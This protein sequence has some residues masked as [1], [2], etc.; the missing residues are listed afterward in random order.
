[1]LNRYL[2][3]LAA[4]CALSSTDLGAQQRAPSSCD[5]YQVAVRADPKNLDAAARLGRCSF[6][7]Y[8]MVA[9]QGDSSRLAFRS[10]WTT[11]LRALRHAV[12]LDPSYS[13]AYRPLFAI[14]FAETRDGC[15]FATGN[16]THV[17][18]V[19]RDGDSVITTPRLVRLNV[20]GID[21][22]DEVT[23]ESR[24]RNRA[25]LSEARVLAERWATVAA[26]DWR[27]HDYLGR[28]LLRLGD[29]AAAA[30]ELERAAGLGTAANR[31]ELFWDRLEALVK[32][33]RGADARRVLDEAVSDP[34]H[35]TI[36]LGTYAVANLNAILGRIRPPSIDSARERQS[37]ARLDSILRS[38]PPA[39]PIASGFSGLLAA[40][41]TIGARRM[42]ARM[43]SAAAPSGGMRR[44][45]RVGPWHLQSAR[46]HLAVGDTAAAE[47][48]LAEIEQTFD[49][50]RFPFGVS[51]TYGGA[52][53]WLGNAWLLTGDLAAARRRFPDAARLY[54]RLVGLWG[55]G[56]AELQPVVGEAR[57][58][59][60]LLPVR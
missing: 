29:P 2:V 28:A 51:L 40:G 20:P 59:L 6:R 23:Q 14:L 16:C 37:R 32:S 54:R 1:M 18:P 19:V 4:C 58:R 56:D 21:T 24:A 13:D 31:R 52:P 43:D 3:S 50:L 47:A 12:E 25:N 49:D 33:D 17:A 15:S 44:F 45:P 26:N 30:N 8:E 42:L 41:D 48:R 10:S 57:A 36:R 35:D 38:R 11:A 9:P 53:S 46:Y 7:D 34:A 5:L 60:A 22:Y 39:P 55:G 27:P